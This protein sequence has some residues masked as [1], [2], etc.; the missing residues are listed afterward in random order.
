MLQTRKG[1]SCSNQQPQYR[2]SALDRNNAQLFTRSGPEIC[3]SNA[4][5]GLSVGVT[6][7]T[8]CVQ[9]GSLLARRM[10]GVL[11]RAFDQRQS[12]QSQDQA[13]RSACKDEPQTANANSVGSM[14]YLALYP[15]AQGPEFRKNKLG[16]VTAIHRSIHNRKRGYETRGS[17]TSH[18]EFR[19]WVPEVSSEGMRQSW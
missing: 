6:E 1:R 10:F 5:S 7:P 17:S 15:P 2:N 19:Q 12:A 9:L 16:S 18:A 3:P 8:R 4:R 14:R 11:R 13:H